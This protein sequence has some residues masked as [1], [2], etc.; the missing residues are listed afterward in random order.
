[1][2]KED[3]VL[4]EILKECNLLERIIVSMFRKTFII[5]FNKYRK[6]IVNI[7]YK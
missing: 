5:I 7:L 4:K 6:I 1:M 3:V 2:K